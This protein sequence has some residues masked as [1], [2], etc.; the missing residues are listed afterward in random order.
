MSKFVDVRLPSSSDVLDA[1]RRLEYLTLLAIGGLLALFYQPY[2]VMAALPLLVL[3]LIL[4]P[5]RCDAIET[6]EKVRHDILH[7]LQRD[8]LD[9]R[10][11]WLLV[12]DEPLTESNAAGRQKVRQETLMWISHCSSRLARF[13]EVAGIFEAHEPREDVMDDL[14]SCLLTLYRIQRLISLSQTLHLPI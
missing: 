13:P 14:E 11:R 4:V 3:A 6:S 8:G 2:A 1:V 12:S 9:L 5:R 10:I 7:E